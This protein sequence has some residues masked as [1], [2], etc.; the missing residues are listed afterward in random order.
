MLWASV[1]GEL[2]YLTYANKKPAGYHLSTLSINILYFNRNT[3]GQ[4][5]CNQGPL[6][7]K[8]RKEKEKS[9]I[10]NMEEKYKYKH[11]KMSTIHTYTLTHSH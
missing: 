3:I 6:A 10:T 4:C 1:L 9:K 8:E 11:V 7:G 2:T 5:N